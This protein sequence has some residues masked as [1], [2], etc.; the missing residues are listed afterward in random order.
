M[1]PKRIFPSLLI[2]LIAY[3][4]VSC[5]QTETNDAQWKGQKPITVVSTATVPIQKQQITTFAVGKGIYLSNDFDGARLNG[6][7]LTADN[8]VTTLI[9][10]ENT[11]INESPWYAF[12]VWADSSKDITLKLT[13]QDGVNHRYYP[14]LSQDGTNWVPID[15]A[16]Y[17][18]GETVMTENNG[19][20]PKDVSLSLK[21]GPDTLWVAGQ[22][23]VTSKHMYAWVDEMAALPYVSAQQIGKSREGRP[24]YAMHFGPDDDKRMV[25]ILSRQ[26]PPEVTGYFAMEAFVEALVSSSETAQQFREQYSTY[27]IPLINPDGVDHGHWRHNVGGVDLNRDWVNVNQPEVA[28]VQQFLEQKLKVSGGKA[29]F[30]V[31]FHSTWRD[32][33]YTI[34]PELTSNM[35]GL[36]DYMIQETSAEL[37]L[38]PNVRP[39]PSSGTKVTSAKYLFYQLGADA[40]T[41]EIG[42]DTPRDLVQKKGEVSAQ[43]VMEYMLSHIPGS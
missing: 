41:Y 8:F 28:A 6:A 14:K 31:D 21:V 19:E 39:S 9:T 34:D 35:P 33:Y 37:G 11:P 16:N 26:H 25:I 30:G 13:Y 23:L 40:L 5:K 7:V 10:A 24:L 42:D 18:I 12:K 3:G 20:R 22:E 36:V 32:I 17:A 4:F 15:S 43:K 1:H 29:Y 2:S 27:V 38:T